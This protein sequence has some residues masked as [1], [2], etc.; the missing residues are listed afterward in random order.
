M[1]WLTAN[2][3][4]PE[5]FK[6]Y[7][8]VFGAVLI[9]ILLMMIPESVE[10][11]D[12]SEVQDSKQQTEETLE[13]ALEEILGKVD[14]AGKVD[15]L[16]TQRTGEQTIYQADE[17]RSQNMIEKETVL[18][19]G[20]D[21]SEEG[22][23]VQVNPPVYLGALVLCQGAENANVRLN[24]VKAVMSVTGLTSDQIAVVKMK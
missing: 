18:V 11:Q 17:N 4:V 7:R 23:V 20:S 10:K 6:K 19:S 16:L 1:E 2:F 14:G 12:Y 15:V 3:S 22:L 21:R 13:S 24:I 5:F 8:F 9:G